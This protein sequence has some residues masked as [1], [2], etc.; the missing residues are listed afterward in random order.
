MSCSDGGQRT[1]AETGSFVYQNSGASR[2]DLRSAIISWVSPAEGNERELQPVF[3][4]ARESPVRAVEGCCCSH[5]LAKLRP[6]ISTLFTDLCSSP[7][8]VSP[9]RTTCGGGTG[10]S[11]LIVASSAWINR[12]PNSTTFPAL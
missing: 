10:N 6:A 3:V 8:P 4:F 7:A 1:A 5:H 9:R 12:R 11:R 2:S